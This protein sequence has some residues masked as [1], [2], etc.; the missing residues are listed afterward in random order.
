MKVHLA[1]AAI[2]LASTSMGFAADMA[3]KAPYVAPAAVWNWTGFYIGGHVGAGWGTTESTLTAVSPGGAIPGGFP[4]AQNSRSGFLGGGQ[5][6]YNFQSGWAVFGVQG[7]IAGMDVKGTT[8][9]L[10]GAASCTAKS[11]WLATVTGRIGGVVGD[12][13]LVYVKGGAAWMH[14]DHSLSVPGGFGPGAGSVGTSTTALGWVLGLGAEY[15]FDHNWSAFI[16]YDYIDFEKKNA[17]LDFSPFAGVP[18]TANVDFKN[19]LSIAKVGLNYKFGGP[20]V[21]RY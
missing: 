14:T 8:P 2:L 19:K 9:C 16:E 1:A 13:T 6:G 4:I 5:A 11:D 21:A 7:D 20:V 12:R 15:A 3:M 18:A 17:A 10:G